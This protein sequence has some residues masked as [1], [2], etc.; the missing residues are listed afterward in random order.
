TSTGKRYCVNSVSLDFV[1]GNETPLNEMD[2]IT[3]GGGCFWCIEAIFERVNGIVSVQSG[4]SGGK[5][6]NPSYESVCSGTTN[7]AEVVQL[8]YN[9]SKISLL[10]VLKVFFSVHNPC[11]LNQQGADYGTQYRSIIFYR[12]NEQK[13]TCEDIIQEL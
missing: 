9:K 6:E 1:K 11:T 13:T 5:T 4:Y 10:E 8:V 12:N 7:H 2:T 3:L